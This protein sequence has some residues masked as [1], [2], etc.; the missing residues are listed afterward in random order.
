[1]GQSAWGKL[2]I[3]DRGV[4]TWQPDAAGKHAYVVSKSTPEDLAEVLDSLLLG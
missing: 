2:T 3:D 4:S 1:M